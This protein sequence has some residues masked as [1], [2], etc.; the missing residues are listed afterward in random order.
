[1]NEKEIPFYVIVIYAICTNVLFN[2]IISRL[3]NF[4]I[5]IIVGSIGGLCFAGLWIVIN[6]II[7]CLKE[8]L[9]DES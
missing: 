2:L 6:E 8:V 9:K 3:W 4:P 5:N 7:E 1:M